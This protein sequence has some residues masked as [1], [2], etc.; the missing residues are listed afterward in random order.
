MQTALNF[1]L[2]D[3]GVKLIHEFCDI[4]W[5]SLFIISERHHSKLPDP[6]LQSWYLDLLQP[7]V[8]LACLCPLPELL[9]STTG[10]GR[11][12]LWLDSLKRNI[13]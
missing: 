5:S 8:I 7:A 9:S 2:V 4:S 11:D 13:A 1:W 12:D 10:S 6:D 3:V